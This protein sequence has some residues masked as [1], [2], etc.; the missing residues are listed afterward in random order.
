MVGCG[1][2]R[3]GKEDAQM[4][5]LRMELPFTEMRRSGDGGPGFWTKTRSEIWSVK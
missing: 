4:F 2:E 5:C 3:A 1:C